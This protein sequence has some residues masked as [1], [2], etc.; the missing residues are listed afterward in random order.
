M[1]GLSGTI[2]ISTSEY[3]PCMV[4]EEKALFHRWGYAAPGEVGMTVAIVERED[5][6]IHRVLP[7]A[8]KFLDSK[9]LFSKYCFQRPEDVTSNGEA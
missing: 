1:N 5:G 3:R 9:S 6:S 8:I 2:T 7:N 4:G